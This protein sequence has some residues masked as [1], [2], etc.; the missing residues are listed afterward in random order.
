MQWDVKVNELIPQ[1]IRTPDVPGG[2][3]GS[4]P[5][6]KTSSRLEEFRDLPG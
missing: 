6:T 1:M 2:S 4:K 3:L 5:T